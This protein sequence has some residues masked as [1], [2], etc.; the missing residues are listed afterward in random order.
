MDRNVSLLILA[1]L[2]SSRQI[3][4][5]RQPQKWR[6]TQIQGA[7]QIQGERQPQKCSCLGSLM[8]FIS[9]CPC[10]EQQEVRWQQEELGSD[11]DRSG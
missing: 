3:Q 9:P 5:E 4:G 11:M 7:T 8:M 2:A 6:M 10:A 1:E